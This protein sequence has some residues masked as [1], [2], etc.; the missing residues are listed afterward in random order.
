ML[1]S[2]IVQCLY[3]YVTLC[4]NIYI[5]INIYICVYLHISARELHEV[6]YSYLTWQVGCQPAS[7]SSALY[8]QLCFEWSTIH[9]RRDHYSTIAAG[10][11]FFWPRTEWLKR[12]WVGDCTNPIGF[13]GKRCRKMHLNDKNP[14]VMARNPRRRRRWRCWRVGGSCSEGR[15][16]TTCFL[17]F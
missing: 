6:S 1:P 9:Q 4:K 12:R 15:T 3:V 13:A 5:Y 8:L 10:G 17:C 16:G 11:A 14:G 2:S 7:E